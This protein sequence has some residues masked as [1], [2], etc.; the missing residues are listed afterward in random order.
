[1]LYGNLRF[2]S[3]FSARAISSSADVRDIAE[4]AAI[5]LTQ[6]GHEG[7]TYNLVGPRILSGSRAASIWSEL[8]KKEVRYTGEALDRWEEQLRKNVSPWMAFDLRMMFQEFLER[9]FIAGEGDVE[10]L[11]KLLGHAPRRYEDFAK[12]TL[13]DW[14]KS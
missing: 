10:A 1:M 11:T 2:P 5:G 13:L 9:G 3:R 14:Q 12:E 8:L 7:K 6:E 4:A